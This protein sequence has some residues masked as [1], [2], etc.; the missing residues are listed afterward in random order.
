M[1]ES[2]RKVLLNAVYGLLII[3]ISTVVVEAQASG[4][5]SS[6][7]HKNSDHKLDQ[8]TRSL[9]RINP[10]TLAMEMSL[11]M[12]N[13]PGRNGNSLPIGISYSSKLWRIDN[14]LTWFYNTTLNG[15]RRFI[16]ELHPLFAERSTA[17]WTSNL[18]FPKIEEETIV[19]N[20]NGKPF[21]ASIDES[22]QTSF[23]EEVL[24]GNYLLPIEPHTQEVQPCSWNCRFT[25]Y[26]ITINERTYHVCGCFSHYFNY[27]G[28]DTSQPNQIPG[29][30]NSGGTGIDLMHYVK[31]V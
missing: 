24:P 9:A 4:G 19:Y 31:R 27:E 16:T 7:Q 8:N 26:T 30:G 28:C 21:T 25:C 11:S 22:Q 12:T 14:G 15:G 29:G 18:D 10:T 3:L 5:S 13:Y 1:R 17:G 2:T 23:L 6:A 20:Q